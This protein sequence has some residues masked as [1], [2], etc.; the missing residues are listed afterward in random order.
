[1]EALALR[2]LR[3]KLTRMRE[4]GSAVT[5]LLDGN[6]SWL[7]GLIYVLGLIF[8]VMTGHDIMPLVN[9][10]LDAT[11]LGAPG[12]RETV[13]LA[14]CAHAA[15]SVWGV[16]SG[17]IKRFKQ[18]KAGATLTEVGSAEGYIKAEVAAIAEALRK[19]QA[20]DEIVSSGIAARSMLPNADVSSSTR[21]P[22]SAR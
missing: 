10:G 9:A 14:I 11:G 16:V 4:R 15:V 1:L 2:A 13:L 6:K 22:S 8:A 18:V 17:A 5:K 20:R 7:S 12:V 21:P 3:Q 19:L